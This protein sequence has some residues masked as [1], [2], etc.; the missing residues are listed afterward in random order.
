MSATRRARPPARLAR[1][2]GP[3][4]S[5]GALSRL[6]QVRPCPGLV[7]APPAGHLK[8]PPAVA[9]WALGKASPTSG[10]PDTHGDTPA[11]GRSVKKCLHPA[12]FIQTNPAA[13]TLVQGTIT[14][15]SL[16]QL[17]SQY[18]WCARHKSTGSR[19]KSVLLSGALGATSQE[20]PSFWSCCV[21]MLR[22]TQQKAS[23]LST[24]DLARSLDAFSAPPLPQCSGPFHL[25]HP[26][27][28]LPQRSLLCLTRG[29]SRP[30]LRV[31]QGL[32]VQGQPAV[33]SSRMLVRHQETQDLVRLWHQL[34]VTPWA[35][36]SPGS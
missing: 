31:C 16:S 21:R 17:L 3:R 20:T 2:L 27:G 6:G 10:P 15:D 13:V 33:A 25:Q 22:G 32:V 8:S 1:G 4:S 5:A 23:L 18:S 30:G 14:L 11:S 7:R 19:T 29:T 12:P 26:T 28:A 34:A 24:W 36:V 35:S 9:F